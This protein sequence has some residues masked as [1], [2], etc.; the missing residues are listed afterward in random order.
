MSETLGGGQ[1]EE[2]IVQW[3]EEPEM[4]GRRTV[5]SGEVDYTKLKR[6]KRRTKQKMVSKG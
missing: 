2:A 4:L 5:D 3:K 1:R 6:E